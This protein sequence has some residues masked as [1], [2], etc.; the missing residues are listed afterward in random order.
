[1]KVETPY[2][3]VWRAPES[4][5]RLLPYPESTPKHRPAFRYDE[6]DTVNHLGQE[7]ITF[8]SCSWHID[9]RQIFQY[10]VVRGSG[11][12]WFDAD[13]SLRA[14]GPH[15]EEPVDPKSVKFEVGDII[16]LWGF[17]PHRASSTR[18]VALLNDGIRSEKGDLR[19][20]RLPLV[21]PLSTERA[22]E[23]LLTRK[24]K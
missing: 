22:F 14:K 15:W 11:K 23:K 4:L 7:Y 16:Q 9:W 19:V 10:I 1:M 6:I 8:K 17:A 24:R 12:L 18:D 20:N 5:T 3:R 13:E 21:T 2:V